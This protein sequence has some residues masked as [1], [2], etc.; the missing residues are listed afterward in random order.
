MYNREH[1]DIRKWTNSSAK[2][3][4]ITEFTALLFLYGANYIYY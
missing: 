3:F 4:S 1:S 2:A